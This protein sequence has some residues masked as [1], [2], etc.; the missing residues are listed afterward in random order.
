MGVLG[1][2]GEDKEAL[3]GHSGGVGVDDGGG[4]DGVNAGDG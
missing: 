1:A 4:N 3:Y 2:I